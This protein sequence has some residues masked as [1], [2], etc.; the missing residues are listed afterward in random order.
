MEYFVAS[1][2]LRDTVEIKFK[3]KGRPMNSGRYSLIQMQDL[4][5]QRKYI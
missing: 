5:I 2:L 3:K 1:T 4:L